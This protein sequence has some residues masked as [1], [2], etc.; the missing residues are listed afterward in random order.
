M[1]Y[2][3]FPREWT[4]SRN[5]SKEALYTAMDADEK[6]KKL[7]VDNVE[8]IR[9]EYL[10]TSQN[11][12]IEGYI[13]EKERYD[14]IH[15]YSI[16]LRKRGAEERIA[17]LLHGVV[18][19]ASV[20]EVRDKNGWLL[21]TCRKSVTT[22][23][24]VE[25]IEKIS[26]IEEGSRLPD[27]LDSKG[28]NSMNLKTFYGS[29]EDRIRAYKA[30]QVTGEYSLED[31]DKNV[32]KADRILAVQNEIDSLKKELNKEKHTFKRA[33]IVK[34]IKSLNEELKKLG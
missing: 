1:N 17:K 21:S 31:V 12:N 20:V 33:E 30:S 9:L 2:F 11:S 8:R 28:F 15:F 27:T 25:G 7:F 34:K 23:I 3:N 29:I 19:K 13:H 14:E 6:L 16:E 4:N 26:W 32:E 18:P 5:I 10:I 24:K 22:A